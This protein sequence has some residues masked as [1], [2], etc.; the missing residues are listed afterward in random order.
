MRNIYSWWRRHEFEHHSLDS[1]SFRVTL[2]LNCTTKPIIDSMT[3]KLLTSELFD[4]KHRTTSIITFLVRIWV[5]KILGSPASEVRA[6]RA[7]LCAISRSLENYKDKVQSDDTY[8]C[9]LLLGLYHCLYQCLYYSLS[10]MSH[11]SIWVINWISYYVICWTGRCR[12]SL[13]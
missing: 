7:K 6:N 13:L 8:S 4:Q 1:E 9:I 5:G 11:S 2:N 12:L 10:L 3:S